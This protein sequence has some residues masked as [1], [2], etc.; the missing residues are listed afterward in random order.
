M[1]DGASKTGITV[2]ELLSEDLYGILIQAAGET[3]PLPAVALYNKLRAAEDYYEHRLQVSFGRKR[4]V[5][6]ARARLGLA[7]AAGLTAADYDLDEVAFDFNPAWF[8]GGRWGQFPLPYRP[9]ASVERVFLAFPGIGYRNPWMIPATWLQVDY[10]LGQL[11]IIPLDGSDLSAVKLQL[12]PVM[13]PWV[14]GTTRIPKVLHVDY[15]VGLTRGELQAGHADLLEAVRI[16]TLLLAFGVLSTVRSGGLGSFSLSADGLS[17]SQ[18]FAAHKW[19]PYGPQIEMAIEREKEI[20]Q[21][22]EASERTGGLLLA[23]A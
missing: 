1:T 17:E 10:R 13:V 20:V 19:G 4:I 12:L 18:N 11:E 8:T 21:S 23:S 16:R 3:K 14:S 6:N 7:S 5:S 9:I 15:T 22:W 2:D